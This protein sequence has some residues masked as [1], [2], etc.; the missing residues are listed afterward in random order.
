MPE[1]ERHAGRGFQP[2]SPVHGRVSVP[3]SKSIAQR[4]IAAASFARGVTE[5]EG[6][7]TSSDVVAALRC[8]RAIG[9]TFPSEGKSDDLLATALMRRSGLGRIAGAPPTRAE[10]ARPWAQVPVGESGTSARL[11]TALASLGRPE[12]SGAEVVPSGTLA[13]RASGSL[14]RALRQAGVGVEHGS[15]DDGWPVLLTAAAPPEAIALD[16]P[17]SSQEVSALLL[18]LAIHPGER[19]LRVRGPIPSRGY[20]DV[21]IG[22]IGAFG[23]DV[24]G[25][26]SMGDEAEG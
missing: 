1:E 12:G 17:G 19:Q 15:A 26:P 9:A 11:F 6:L 2:G 25:V 14:F 5:I 23:G 13:R 16:Q 8:S 18:A 22:V 4:A 21:T 20:V 10:R 3:A 7:P 24:R